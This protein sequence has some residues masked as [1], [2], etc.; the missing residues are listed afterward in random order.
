[1]E[2]LLFFPPLPFYLYLILWNLEKFRAVSERCLCVIL[3]DNKKV[4]SQRDHFLF[5]KGPFYPFHSVFPIMNDL[6]CLKWEWI[7]QTATRVSL[8]RKT[9][10]H[11][12][13]LFDFMWCQ[14]KSITHECSLGWGSHKNLPFFSHLAQI[15]WRRSVLSIRCLSFWLSV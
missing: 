15:A 8:L 13:M 10:T 9:L 14:I 1:M 3:Q 2:L 5:Q 6:K 11:R 4:C 12:I 7:A